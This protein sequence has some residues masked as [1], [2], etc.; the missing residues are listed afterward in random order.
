M[1]DETIILQSY[2]NGG[3]FSEDDCLVKERINLLSETFYMCKKK[4][5]LSEGLKGTNA[6]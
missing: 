1:T 3:L 2:L 5:D 4:N 6:S